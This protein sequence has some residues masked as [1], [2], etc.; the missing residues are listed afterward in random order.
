MTNNKRKEIAKIIKDNLELVGIKSSIIVSD[1]AYK[2]LKIKNYDMVLTGSI[3]P[4][5]PEI[6][7]FINYEPQLLPT[8][9]KTYLNIYEQFKSQPSFIGIGFNQITIISSKSIK[10]NINGNWFNIFLG[11]DTWY[12][13]K[14]N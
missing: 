4:L 13:A 1:I 9:E 11:I 12:K 8:I 14:K 7:E 5:K 6:K 3:V 10:G 2:N